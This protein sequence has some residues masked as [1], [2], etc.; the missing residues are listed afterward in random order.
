MQND[1]TSEIYY[2]NLTLNRHIGG[3]ENPLL[4][5]S[6][7]YIDEQQYILD[8][9]NI[10]LPPANRYNTN[11]GNNLVQNNNNIDMQS[12]GYNNGNM[13]IRGYLNN[14]YQVG[15]NLYGIGINN[16]GYNNR[17]VGYNE[18][19]HKKD[20]YLR[21]DA[22]R[23]DLYDGF[24]YSKGLMNDGHQRRRIK[25]K[26]IDINSEFRNKLPSVIT[27]SSILLHQDPLQF[28]NNSNTIFIKH[29]NNNFQVNDSI[30][31]T[32]VV[33]KIA[34]LR[35]FR[36]TNQPTFEIP[37]G[38]NFM[39][40]YYN[41]GVPITY[42]G[43][44]IFITLS[45]IKG[46]RGTS[47]YT[48]FLGSV[49]TNVINSMHQLYMTL[50]ND[51]INCDTETVKINTGDP[52]Y[53]KASPNYFFIVLASTMQD[54]PDSDPYTLRDYNFRLIFDS[55]YGIPLNQINATYPV[56]QNNIYGYHVI[57]SVT[58]DGYS[59]DLPTKAVSQTVS[60]LGGGSCVYVSKITSVDNGYPDPNN[61]KLELG[62][63]F[64]NV[65]TVRLVSSE[66]PNTEKAIQDYP[67]SKA[68]NKIYWNDIDDG[69]YLYSISIPPGNYSP[70]SLINELNKQF[71]A[72]PRISTIDPSQAVALGITYSSTHY[73]QTTINENTNEVIF[74]SYKQFIVQKPIIE[75]IPDIPDS[76]V[77]QADPNVTYQLTI[78]NP[79]HGMVVP[80]QTILIQ[81]AIDNKG[82]PASV[83][84]GEHVVTEIIDKDK[85]R[86]TL[87][88]FNL[89]DDRTETGGGVN[90]FIYIPDIFR[91]RFDYPD[92]LGK[93][94]G[95]RN[96]GS[97]TSITNYKSIISNKDPYTFETGVN[98]LGQTINITN[99]ALQLSGNNYI[100]MVADPIK[101]YYSIG[102]IKNAFAKI[103]LCDSPGKFLYNTFV[104]MFQ[105][106]DDPLHELV[107]LN[108]QFYNPDGSLYDFNGID[109][110]YTLEIV[111]ITDIPEGTGI[112]ANTGKNYN[113]E[114]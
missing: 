94:L 4:Q 61:Y 66:I 34:T 43:N 73:I 30:T 5:S 3:Y 24:L 58:N 31:L 17:D 107:S 44:S 41:H 50:T 111:T 113:Q 7:Q 86:I 112:N 64:H 45:G 72:T 1:T 8:N 14:N 27:E 89:L 19:K 93:V 36:G 68:N 104:N 100:I 21:N 60:S 6:K 91:M 82:I 59:I 80:G 40:I 42:T 12:S 114:I 99:N 38:C 77:I 92:T 35:T 2:K 105:I 20:V 26:F 32:N 33:S 87:P 48:S 70:Q 47:D 52:N 22:D 74:K 39:K 37:G 75:I 11:N 49:P 78:N 16:N 28:T 83:I 51:N 101:T 90:V 54:V 109:H 88:K 67:P 63:V 13:S 10:K 9:N 46:D 56:T 110:S 18:A 55:L 98:A 53:F 57:K 102:K 62:D 103:I 84:N 69:D 108:I 65:I 79:G 97:P 25:S 76:S 71:L 81:N 15:A 23:Y 95:F 96:P 29:P 85:Y 106:F